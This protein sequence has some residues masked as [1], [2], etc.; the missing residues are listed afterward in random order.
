MNF[1]QFPHITVTC[2]WRFA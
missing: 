2:H 1:L